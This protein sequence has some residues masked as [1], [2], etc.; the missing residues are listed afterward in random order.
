MYVDYPIGSLPE[1][2]REAA[3]TIEVYAH[4]GDKPYIEGKFPLLKGVLAIGIPSFI[5]TT[6]RIL[7]ANTHTKK[8]TPFLNT[9]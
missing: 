5:K 6:G 4:E 1:I 2:L 8:G 7:S 9:T 3:G